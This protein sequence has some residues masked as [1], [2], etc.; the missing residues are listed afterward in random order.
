[1][2]GL[3]LV[4]IDG[5]SADTF[6]IRRGRLANLASL[7]ASGLVVERLSAAVPGTSLPGRASILT[8][9]PARRNGVYGNRLLDEAHGAFRYAS[10]YDVRL[11]T[12]PRL[13]RE[14]GSTTAAVGMGMVRPEDVDVF[15]HPWWVGSF[16]QRARDARPEPLANGWENVA[17]TLDPSGALAEAAAKAGVPDAFDALDLDDASVAAMAGFLGDRRVAE[18]VGALAT[19]DDAPDLIVTELLMTDTVQHRSGYDTPLSQWTTT[20][21]DGLIGDL[22][23]RLRDAGREDA[24]D[25]MILSDHGHGPVER[26]LRPDVLLPGETFVSEGGLLHVLTPDAPTRERVTGILAEVGAQAYPTAYLPDD[27]QGVLSSFLAPDGV[28][29]EHDGEAPDGPW[30]TPSA[31]SSHGKR[32]GHPDDDRFLLLAGPRIEGGVVPRAEAADVAATAARLLGLDVA[33]FE[34]TPL[35]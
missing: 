16:V 30:A 17:G 3:I 21:M 20:L 5:V 34:G 10:P 4:M 15:A 18:W 11:P 24:Y 35:V 9:A 23:A 12:L 25:L 32:P 8:G 31:V 19:S 6:R 1:M 2:A 22:L 28:S 13:A 27:L 33:P 7:A 29:F 26:A 14:A